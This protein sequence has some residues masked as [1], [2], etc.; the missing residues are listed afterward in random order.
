MS[1]TYSYAGG[2]YEQSRSLGAH[3]LQLTQ[4]QNAGQPR[5]ILHALQNNLLTGNATHLEAFVFDVY[6]LDFGE[7][8]AGLHGRLVEQ[9]SSMV[10]DAVE[11]LIETC[12]LSSVTIVAHSIGGYA[13]RLALVDYPELPNMVRNVITLA[14]PHAYPV[15]AIEPSLH[16]VF[17]RFGQEQNTQVALIS[18]GGGWRDEM[19]PPRSCQAPNALNLGA[20]DIMSN[21][22]KT[23]PLLGM[24]HRAIVWCHNLLSKVREI[25][26]TL[27]RNDDKDAPIRL[28]EVA[29]RLEIPSDYN[30]LDSVERTRMVYV[31]R[32]KKN[33]VTDQESSHFSYNALRLDRNPSDGGDLYWRR[34]V[35]CT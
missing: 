16:R 24:D 30:Y 34:M 3:G 17:S 7:E 26:F 6:A 9:Q 14:T 20:V 11:F 2:S 21:G 23:V 1:V 13:T 10:A 12:E 4:R 29:N 18:I 5:R 35:S 33:V 32:Q 22:R 8:G 15:L 19:I 28:R 31:V 27:N 25:I